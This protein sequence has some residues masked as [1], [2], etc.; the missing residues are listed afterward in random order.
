D[1]RD[2]AERPRNRITYAGPTYVD[3]LSW[4]GKDRQ[5]WLRYCRESNLGN[6]V[7][8]QR[9]DAIC[10]GGR[11]RTPRRDPDAEHEQCPTDRNDQVQ[12]PLAATLDRGDVERRQASR[13]HLQLLLR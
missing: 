9:R 6:G 4:F 12:R 8:Q 2:R 5:L 10:R 1:K 3:H 13:T 7:P 11:V